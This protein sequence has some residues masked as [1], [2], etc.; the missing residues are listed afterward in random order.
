MILD[1]LLRWQIEIGMLGAACLFVPWNRRRPHFLFRAVL[2]VG[3]LFAVAYLE[4]ALMKDGW[5][6]ALPTYV[7]SLLLDTALL[8]LL[9]WRSFDCSP[10]HAMF[11]ATCAYAVQHMTSK[12]A[13]MDVMILHCIA[14]NDSWETKSAFVC[15]LSRR[16][17][18]K[19]R[20]AEA[21]AF[22]WRPGR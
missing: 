6:S 15:R 7:I 2:G 22:E 10:V 20:Q 8:V 12:L 19:Q 11:S 9:I 21:P 13:Y 14:K 16:Q 1:F 4:S 3:L 18:A 5:R 17:S